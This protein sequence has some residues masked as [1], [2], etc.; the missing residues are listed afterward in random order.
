MATIIKKK[1]RTVPLFGPPTNP[2]KPQWIAEESLLCPVSNTVVYGKIPQLSYR[3]SVIFP[4][5][6]IYFKYGIH[7][8]PGS[9]FGFQHVWKEHYPHVKDHDD[10]MERACRMIAK[11][12]RPNAQVFYDPLHPANIRA[13]SRVTAFRL[14]VGNV[15][16]A[17]RD[18]DTPFYSIVTGGF[19][20]ANAKGSLIGALA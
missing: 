7:Y 19:G 6:D 13:A 11:V 9:G 12:F 14:H 1:T 10:A 17:L 4:A 5:G 8:G 16:I 20:G 3:G 18:E 2:P 15:V